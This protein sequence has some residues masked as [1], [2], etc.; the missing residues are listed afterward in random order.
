M[1]L[2]VQLLSRRGAGRLL[3]SARPTHWG[4]FFPLMEPLMFSKTL[5]STSLLLALALVGCGD[6][7]GDRTTDGVDAATTPMDDDAGMT[8]DPTG[9]ALTVNVPAD[10]MGTPD[11]L[12]VVASDTVPPMGPPAAILLMDDD[13][14]ATAGESI[15]L[16]LDTSSLSGDYFIIAILFMEGGGMFQPTAGVDYAA[17]TDTAITFDGEPT[18]LGSLDLALT[19]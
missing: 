11:R 13:I 9:S 5:I 14:E 3:G 6:D 16:D 15:E 18:D 8:P 12:F 10:L 17:A 7:A 1:K 4:A 2:E 19:E